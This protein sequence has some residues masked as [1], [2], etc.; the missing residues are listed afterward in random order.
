MVRVVNNK[1]NLLVFIWYLYVTR[2]RT[3][4]YNVSIY[5]LRIAGLY[6]IFI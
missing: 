4:A 2:V 1:N 6:V 5:A 3:L